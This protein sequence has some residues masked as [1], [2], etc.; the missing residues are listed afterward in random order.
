MTEPTELWALARELAAVA[1]TEPRLRNAA[2]RLY[3]AVFHA[4]R[5]HLSVDT[6]GEH[7]HDRV[8][9]ALKATRDLER[10]RAGGRLE[11]L[12]KARVH[13][14]YQLR[15]TFVRAD[16]ESAQNHAEAVLSLLGLPTP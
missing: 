16:L 3:Y 11:S 9:Q 6:S 1:E 5:I 2:G 8:I 4:V 13:A 12:R 7:A 14:D 15:R 10:V